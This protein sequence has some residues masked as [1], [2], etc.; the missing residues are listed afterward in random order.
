MR[1]PLIL[2]TSGWLFAL[3]GEEPYAAELE[4]ATQLILPGLVLA[5]VDYHLRKRRSAMHRLLDEVAAGLYDYQPPSSEDLVRARELDR[6]FRTS[7]LGLVDCSIA[8]LA[9]RL[10]VR[11]VLT[12]DADF[13]VIRF[14][15]HWRESIELVGG[16]RRS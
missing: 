2:D 9:E 4:D 6:K 10:R 3:E 12:A 8:A 1:A 16:P 11:R 5:E 14:G 13:S 7:N 15:A